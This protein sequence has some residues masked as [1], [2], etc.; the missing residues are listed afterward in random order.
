MQK[1]LIS[2]LAIGLPLNAMAWQSGDESIRGPLRALIPHAPTELNNEHGLIWQQS[3]Q[4]AGLPVALVSEFDA[5]YWTDNVGFP[6]PLTSSNTQTTRPYALNGMSALPDH[7]FSLWDWAAGNLTCPIGAPD[8]SAVECHAAVGD[9]GP[10]GA[11]HFLPQAQLTYNHYHTLALDRAR[12]CAA[13]GSDLDDAGSDIDN[14]LD[15]DDYITECEREALLLEA[16][17]QHFLQDAWAIGHMWE[18]WGSSDIEDFADDDLAGAV[19]MGAAL[20]HG[21]EPV[22]D[23][24]DDLSSSL[25]PDVDFSQNGSVSAGTGDLNLAELNNNALYAAQRTGLLRCAAAGIRAVY[26]ETPMRSGAM[27]AYSG[28]GTLATNTELLGNACFGQRATD[29]AMLVAIGLSGNSVVRDVQLTGATTLTRNTGVELDELSE[30]FRLELLRLLS[31]S[32]LSELGESDLPTSGLASGNGALSEF[33]GVEPNAAFD[34]L[35]P[36]VDPEIASEWPLPAGESIGAQN[37]AFDARPSRVLAR[38]FNRSHLT[39]WCGEAEA[40][41]AALRDQFQ[42]APTG[43]R[44]ALCEEFTIR[45]VRPVGGQSLC[46]AV[47]LGTFTILAEAGQSAANGANLFCNPPPPL[48]ITAELQEPNPF[49]ASVTVDLPGGGGTDTD[50]DNSLP[51]SVSADVDDVDHEIEGE[52]DS[53][54]GISISGPSATFTGSV[55]AR[56]ALSRLQLLS[57]FGGEAS[58]N[59]EWSVSFTISTDADYRLTVNTSGSVSGF[60]TQ[61][62]GALGVLLT[63]NVSGDL[64]AF[65]A[66]GCGASYPNAI[67][68][69]VE[70]T[71]AAGTYEL[72]ITSDTPLAADWL[73]EGSLGDPELLIDST[74]ELRI[75]EEGEDF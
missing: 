68:Q 27:G 39:G 74:F 31:V 50:N 2:L 10:V 37:N 67:S 60:P 4:F 70:G 1:L 17:G 19:A 66:D 32:W 69:Q 16:F 52:I 3:M 45:H 51:V 59:I 29:E 28:P 54:A 61:C 23:V 8:G 72:T 62:T 26:S 15:A 46:E 75:V 49:V 53:D 18:R 33:M 71:L 56:L 25:S 42:A 14:G 47:G 6:A 5:V 65:Y 7:S 44:L 12:Q 41:P 11:R 24:A 34:E 57:A 38:V 43:A 55:D 35:A 36:Y 63:E 48:E 30:F 20:I 9:M 21:A 13:L 40:S 64:Q 73:L 22:L 58:G